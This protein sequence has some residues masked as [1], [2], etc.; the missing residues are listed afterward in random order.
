[1]SSY[2]DLVRS[3]FLTAPPAIPGGAPRVIQLAE[4]FLYHLIRY[5]DHFNLESF[6]SCARFPDPDDMLLVQALEA[7]KAHVS[8]YLPFCNPPVWMSTVRRP[9]RSQFP[10]NT[11]CF[12]DEAKLALFVTWSFAQ[13]KLSNSLD[14]IVQS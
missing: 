14:S 2:I 5:P 4:I 8:P 9:V 13:D 11:L 7:L 12:L 1:M 3:G 10:K 6:L